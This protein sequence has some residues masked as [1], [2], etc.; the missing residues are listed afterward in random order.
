MKKRKLIPRVALASTIFTALLL[1]QTV[2]GE[3]T[4]DDPRMI[5][6]VKTEKQVKAEKE[7]LRK[8]REHITNKREAAESEGKVSALGLFRVISVPSFEQETSYWCGPATVKQVLDY[9]NGTSKSQRYYADELGTTKD[10]T[11]FSVVDDVLNDHQD[12]NYYVYTT[13]DSDEQSK[14]N[15]KIEWGID[16]GYP[17]ILD[18]KNDPDYMPKYTRSVAGHIVNTSGYDWDDWEIRITDPFDQ[19]N[20]GVTLGNVWHPAD[21][22]WEANQAHFRQAMIW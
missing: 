4:G 10:G 14:F 18:L 19:G 8:V 15:D 20:R 3:G 17:S 22:I 1:P 13:H 12:E 21:G 2:M 11:V 5:E 16:N 6:D 9:I 7:K